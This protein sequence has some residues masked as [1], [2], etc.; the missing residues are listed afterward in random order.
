MLSGMRIY[1]ADNIWRQILGELGA[2][3]LDA[4]SV[5]GINFDD[6]QIDSPITPI[7]L[8]SLLLNAQ[9]SGCIIRCVFGRDVSLSYLQ[10]MIIV[11]LYKSGGMTSQELKSAFGGV[12]NISTH[13]VDTAIYQLRRTYGHGF[14]TNKEG[15]YQIGEL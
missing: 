9:D 10:S 13:A 11:W 3:V 8:K 1:S 5:S 4:P 15:V 7:E 6:I 14:I 12:H 2:I